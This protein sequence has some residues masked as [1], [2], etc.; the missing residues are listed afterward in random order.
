VV[1]LY[2]SPEALPEDSDDGCSLEAL[3]FTADEE[4]G[5]WVWKIL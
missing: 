3:G 4:S 1:C 5:T 2:I